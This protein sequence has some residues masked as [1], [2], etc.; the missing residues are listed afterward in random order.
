MATDFELELLE[1]LTE[2]FR[3]IMGLKEEA[4]DYHL[5]PVWQGVV[6]EAINH[7][8]A[9][10]DAWGVPDSLTDFG[11]GHVAGL[12]RAIYHLKSLLPDE[13][14]HETTDP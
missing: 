6:D 10:R 5:S 2:A 13:A 9:K 11:K 14:P 3:E 7:L 8:I 1:R 12:D 4:R